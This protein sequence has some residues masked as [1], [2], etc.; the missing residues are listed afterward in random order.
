M[1][2]LK[3]K[4]SENIVEIIKKPLNFNEQQ[5]G[6]E[7]KMLTPKQLLQRLPIAI[8][9]VKA[10]NTSKNLLNKIRQIKY[11]CIEKKKFL[12]KYITT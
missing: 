10:G 11:F 4:Y 9:Q 3:I 8:A 6:K 1:K 7:I 5:K 2:F 12:K